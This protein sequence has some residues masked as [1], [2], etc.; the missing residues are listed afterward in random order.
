MIATLTEEERTIL[1]HALGLDRGKISYR[2]GY[3]DHPRSPTYRTCMTLVRKGLME[4]GAFDLT[5]I[6]FHVTPEGRELI[7][8]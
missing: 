3:V 1:V 5:H 8:E 6:N 2:N 7:R 4:R